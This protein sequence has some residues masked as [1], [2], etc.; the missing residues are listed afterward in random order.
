MEDSLPTSI[1]TDLIPPTRQADTPSAGATDSSL[2]ARI[3]R[4]QQAV[5]AVQALSS[6]HIAAAETAT[7]EEAISATICRLHAFVGAVQRLTDYLDNNDDAQSPTYTDTA[8]SA[9]LQQEMTVV[10]GPGADAAT[11]VKPLHSGS[12]SAAD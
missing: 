11:A 5:Q 3:A 2:E 7:Q 8:P 6:A 12:G 10:L 1:S 4:L 9:T